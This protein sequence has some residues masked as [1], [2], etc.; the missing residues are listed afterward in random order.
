VVEALVSVLSADE[1]T[2]AARFV[3]AR[4]RRRFVVT[5]ACLRT[6]LGRLSGDSPAAIQFAYGPHGKPALAPDGSGPAA[7]FSVSHS[8]DLALIA[9]GAGQPLG[10]DLEA[11]RPI[12]DLEQIAT[13]FFTPAEART[14]ATV[15]PAQRTL[16]FLLCWT[17]K[18]AF[19]KALGGGLSVPL[20]SYQ[21]ACHPGEPARLV[22]VAGD[23][24]EAA[25][26][27]VFDL[28]PTP[29]FVSAVVVR[30]R[31]APPEVT[32]LDV[33][34]EVLPS[35][36]PDRSQARAARE[37]AVALRARGNCT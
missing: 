9:L 31:P 26:W 11:V 6:L 25:R 7:H 4:D 37:P 22:D 35:V 30:A 24:T 14:I 10:V 18:E 27:S 20:D 19:A 2:R 1:R 21:V 32:A 8:E 34:R 12:A 28:R 17:R 23:P 33:D 29:G 3:F 5:R 36:V 16:A 15:P 13:R